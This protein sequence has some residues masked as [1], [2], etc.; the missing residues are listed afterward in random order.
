MLGMSPAMPLRAFAVLLL[1]G[2]LLAPAAPVWA[3]TCVQPSGPDVAFGQAEAVF[4]GTVTGISNSGGLNLLDRVRRIFG[5]PPTVVWMDPRMVTL[6]VADSW[7][8][9]TE[10]PVRLF[11]G[12]GGGD[13]GYDFSVGGQYLVYGYY[14]TGRLGTNVCQ[15]TADLSQ[16]GPDLA[17]LQSQPNLPVTQIPGSLTP[18]VFFL[19]CA[20]LLALSALAAGGLW[21]WRRRAS[22]PV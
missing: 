6:A 1:A 10:S 11:T 12:S 22:R 3:C 13:C 2:L 8:G 15:R 20:S 21:L 9:V 18:P 5:Q 19:A 14:N 7:K 4:T 16:A 17:Y